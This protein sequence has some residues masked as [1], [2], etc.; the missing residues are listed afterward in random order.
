MFA[1]LASFLTPA[2]IF[3]SYS[4]LQVFRRSARSL[5]L[6]EESTGSAPQAT[7]GDQARN[8]F[9]RVQ[10][11][12][13]EAS[14]RFGTWVSLFGSP[15]GTAK[16]ATWLDLAPP[17]PAARSNEPRVHEPGATRE[18]RA[19]GLSLHDVVILLS[20]AYIRVDLL[21]MVVAVADVRRGLTT[22]HCHSP[23]GH[24][25]IMPRAVAHNPYLCAA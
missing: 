8:E 21:V 25:V 17:P 20:C 5:A 4:L 12:W 13:K 9:Q 14:P 11:R 24:R 15:A 2:N 3:S 22:Q 10:A 16:L 1:S 23:L 7:A 19:V 18:P 6:C